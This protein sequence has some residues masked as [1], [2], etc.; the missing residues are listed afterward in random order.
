MEQECAC[1]TQTYKYHA[2]LQELKEAV[3][4]ALAYI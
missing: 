4:L 3:C 2:G 1:I